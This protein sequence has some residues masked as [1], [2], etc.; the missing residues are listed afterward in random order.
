MFTELF[1]IGC[2]FPACHGG[3]AKYQ[4][5]LI[6]HRPTL[7]LYQDLTPP[8]WKPFCHEY[9]WLVGYTSHLV[10]QCYYLVL[11]N[12]GTLQQIFNGRGRRGWQQKGGRGTETE[13]GGGQER[14]SKNQGGREVRKKGPGQKEVTQK[15]RLEERWEH[16]SHATRRAT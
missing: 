6:F 9:L 5:C 2:T 15:Q 16:H 1:R 3:S 12:W 7:T 4:T 10:L 14:G 8:T 11:N 13:G